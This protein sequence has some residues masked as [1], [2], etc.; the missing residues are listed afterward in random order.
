MEEDRRVAAMA[1]QRHAHVPGPALPDGRLSPLVREREGRPV[2]AENPWQPTL[3]GQLVE[4]RPLRPEDHDALYA[5]ASDPMIWAQH[6]DKTR[7][8]PPGFRAFFDGAMASGGAF[9][10]VDRAT[11]H[12]IGS[13]RFH[14]HDA[15]TSVVEIGW[16]FLARACWGGVYNR[17]VKHLMLRHAFRFVRRVVFL[18]DSKNLRSQRAM[19]KI[20]GVQVASTP[21]VEGRE[22]YVFE[23][24]ASGFGPA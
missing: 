16:T 6:P 22:T 23:I 3:T 12:V 4:L 5:V 9:L 17:D 18:V 2:T 20:G 1:A 24:T 21:G 11:Q 15:E 8:Q 13:S 10:I 14:G 19:V 7:S